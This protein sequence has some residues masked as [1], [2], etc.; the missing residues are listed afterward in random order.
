MTARQV[1]ISSIDALAVGSV[2]ENVDDKLL[3]AR[4]NAFHMIASQ[5]A[6]S[7]GP[8]EK[9]VVTPARLEPLLLHDI[10]V[11]MGATI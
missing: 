10:H 5:F 8:V 4:A 1:P 7:R 2:A 6:L 9:P 3:V 11:A